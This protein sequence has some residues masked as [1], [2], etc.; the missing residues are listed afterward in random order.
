M[1]AAAW[2]VA[3]VCWPRCAGPAHRGDHLR[4]GGRSPGTFSNVPLNVTVGIRLVLDRQSGGI[5][6]I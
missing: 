6:P 4:S 3:T 5:D 2:L 1:T